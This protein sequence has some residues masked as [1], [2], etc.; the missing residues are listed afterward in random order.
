MQRYILRP[1]AVVPVDLDLGKVL[2]TTFPNSPVGPPEKAFL[3]ILI[4]KRDRDALRFLW[5]QAMPTGVDDKLEIWRMTRVT[6]GTGPS[7]FMLAAT[8]KKLLRESEV[9]YPETTRLLNDC[10]YVDDFISVADCEEGAI[11]VYNEVKNIMPKGS[12]NMRKWASNSARLNALY[13]QDPEEVSPFAG[14]SRVIKV[15]GMKWDTEQ[16]SLFYNATNL[17]QGGRPAVWTKRKVLQRAQSIYDPLG[18]MSPYTIAARIYMQKMWQQRFTWDQPIPADLQES[19]ERWYEDL[20]YLTEI[21]FNRYYG[22][23]P[24]NVPLHVFCDASYNAY[25]AVAYLVIKTSDSSSNGSDASS[26]S[27][28]KGQG[29]TSQEADASKVGT[30]SRCC[31]CENF[32]NVDGRIPKHQTGFL[33]D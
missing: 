7:T 20:Q 13:V 10:T 31:S 23:W 9:D 14:D 3:Q 8:L 19:W 5:Y 29:S 22:M 24:K 4:H 2:Y 33:L 6:F 1:H 15:L 18:L 12:M 17:L 25:G 11:N 28:G 32:K 21:K 26:N 30:P 16:D 27:A